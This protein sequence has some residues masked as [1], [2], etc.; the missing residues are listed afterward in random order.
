MKL[1]FKPKK[2]E[3]KVSKP[4]TEKLDEIEFE[5]KLGVTHADNAENAG[6]LAGEKSM[7]EKIKKLI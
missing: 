2:E 3:K 4:F 7:L 5:V 6:H 1:K